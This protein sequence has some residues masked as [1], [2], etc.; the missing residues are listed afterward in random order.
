MFSF[1]KGFTFSILGN[2]IRGKLTELSKEV[3]F[4][5]S[6]GQIN[7]RFVSLVN[8]QGFHFA[9]YSPT[10]VLEAKLSIGLGF[11]GTRSGVGVWSSI[12]RDSGWQCGTL[13][14]LAIESMLMDFVWKIWLKWSHPVTN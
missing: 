14:A 12:W 1:S 5:T 4:F 2:T 8:M 10:K 7:C 13:L 11:R 9:K 6:Q 3:H